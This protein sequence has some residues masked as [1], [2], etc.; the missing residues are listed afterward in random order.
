MASA[1]SAV[2]N[3]F[4]QGLRAR[5]TGLAAAPELNGLVGRLQAYHADRGRWAVALPG[6]AVPKLLKPSNLEPLEAEPFDFAN[7]FVDVLADDVVHRMCAF[8]PGKALLDISA[9]TTVLCRHAQ[10]SPAL[11]RSLCR[12]LLGDALVRLHEV[13][14]GKESWNDEA[15]FWRDLF[16]AGYQGRAFHYANDVRQRCIHQTPALMPPLDPQKNT[17]SFFVLDSTRQ[18]EGLE[19]CFAASGHTACAIGERVAVIGGWRPSEPGHDLHVT[20]IDLVA[21]RIVEPSLAATSARP[22][23]R[24]RHSSCAIC[25]NGTAGVGGD[26]TST[27][28]GEPPLSVLVL[29]GCNDANHEPCAG[30]HLLLVLDFTTPD[31]SEV[32]WREIAADGDAPRAIWHHSC[33]SYSGGK[34]VVVFGGD[35]PRGDPEFHHIGDRAY[36][37]HVYVLDVDARRWERVATSGQVP[38]WRSLHTGVAYT[39][40]ADGSER[41][42]IMGGC[43]EHLRIFTGGKPASMVG[44]SLNLAT[45]KWQRGGRAVKRGVASGSA[46]ANQFVPQPRMRFAAERYGRHLLVYGGHSDADLEAKG[47]QLLTLNLMTL[48]WQSPEITNEPEQ[49]MQAPAATLAGGCLVGGVRFSPQGVEPIPKFDLVCLCPDDG[50]HPE[51]LE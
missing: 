8:L 24:L 1:E 22:S 42:V 46:R 7:I 9:T 37:S 23:R 51:T 32:S 15:E 28:G 18:S 6:A 48:Q 33:G 19:R 5:L 44:Y 47:E 39:S 26:D 25:L 3:Q 14:W 50:Y 13:A 2:A 21:M 41:F 16:R 11:W 17:G 20:V 49:F 10:R 27:R 4:R 36:A 43:E 30:L 40:L 35:F 12:S 34:R 38:C 31:A 45:M 29:G